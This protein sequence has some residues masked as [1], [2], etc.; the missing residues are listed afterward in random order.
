MSRRKLRRLALREA[1]RKR[2]LARGDLVVGARALLRNEILPPEKIEKI[3]ADSA[4]WGRMVR[5]ASIKAE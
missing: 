4:K 2:R 1:H 3:K 5:E